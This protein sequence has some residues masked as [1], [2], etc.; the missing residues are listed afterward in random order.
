MRIVLGKAMELEDPEN[1]DLG[2]VRTLYFK[3]YY[4]C[5]TCFLSV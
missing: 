1:C 2:I 5:E 4:K 3:L